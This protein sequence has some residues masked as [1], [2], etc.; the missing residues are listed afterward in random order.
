MRIRDV[1]PDSQSLRPQADLNYVLVARELGADRRL[2][3]MSVDLA[4]AWAGESQ[5]NL[6]LAERDKIIVFGIG[7][8]RAERIA[9]LLET[10][11]MQS[12]S[13]EPSA[14]VR[15]GGR[16]TAAGEY[17][18]EPDMR[19]SD[20]LRAA[21][22][23]QEAAYTLQAELARYDIVGEQSRQTDLLSIDLAAVLAGGRDADVR[24]QSYDHLIVKEIPQWQEQE[25]VE[26]EGEVRFPGTYL[27]KRGETLSA[28]LTRAG[29]LTDL[30]FAD[31]S[32]FVREDLKRREQEQ[33]ENLASRL[34][35]DIVS[36]SLR[37]LQTDAD[38]VQTLSIGQS[39][40]Q[41]LRETE[42]SGRL[43]IDVAN[44]LANPDDPVYDIVMR[45]GDRLFIP[46]QTQE[47]TVLGEVQYATSHIYE[48][49][50]G[51]A[52][53]IS[54]SGGLTQKADRKRIYVVRAN[55]AVLSGEGSRWF[56]RSNSVEI[57]PGD[58][59]VVP[60]DADRIGS[61][62]LWTSVSQIIYQLGL[63]AAS[64]NAVGIF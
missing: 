37:S 39:L 10:L 50:L 60:L 53:Y 45:D 47:V 57:R 25:S 22:G 4:A 31:G 6:L 64:A 38:A 3:L 40:L 48:P 12:R 21:G 17:P 52:A 23:L 51:R 44:V 1:L 29:G 24:L 54:R 20:L 56:K 5:E 32:L 49:G 61:L 11:R 42:A 27:L 41:Q 13:G 8:D 43:V 36:F 59:I 63:A 14:E 30:A 46:G 18:L 58:T 2:Q 35:A 34:E 55:G 26:L 28:V 7:P 16:V 15:I 19:V 9:P 33:I 62:A